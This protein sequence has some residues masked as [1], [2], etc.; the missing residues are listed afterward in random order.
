MSR[1]IIKLRRDVQA[2]WESVNPVLSLGEAGIETDTYRFKIGNGVDQW[3]DL[4][5]ML[6]GSGIPVINEQIDDR[7][8]DLLVAGS[9]I[10]L[11]YN[12]SGNA[13]T[14]SESPNHYAS[15]YDTTTQINN[16]ITGVNT[17]SFNTTVHSN[18]ISIVSGNRI[19]FS[20]SG[21]FNLQF[22]AQI[23]KTDGGD[24]RIDIWISKTGV[25]EDWTN[26]TLTLHQQDAKTVAAWNYIISAN[27]GEYYQMH[28]HSS[29]INLR[30]LAES[31]L[32]NPTRP[33]I[34]SIIL[35]LVEV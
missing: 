34:P 9:G 12:D 30:L 1:A 2:N 18:G 19:S 7:V 3:N 24:D 11:S 27:S 16:S 4:T 35:T 25:N 14:I 20:R 26:T 31:G 28:W 13:L 15:F 32:T 23:D 29:D 5:F 17:I 22:S 21:I 8:S 6:G 10:T 33:S